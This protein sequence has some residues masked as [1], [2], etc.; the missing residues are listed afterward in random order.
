[1][2]INQR[3]RG[4]H[5][6]YISN[7]YTIDCRLGTNPKGRPPLSYAIKETLLDD[8]SDYYSFDYIAK[9]SVLTAN[10]IGTDPDR[11]FF[12]N[13]SMPMLSTIFSKLLGDNMTMLGL[14]PQFVDAVS[15]FIKLGGSYSSIKYSPSVIPTLCEKIRTTAPSVVYIDNP[16]NPTGRAYSHEELEPVVEVCLDSGSILL[17]D[18]AYGDYLAKDESMVQ[19]ANEFNN[20]V[21][22]RSFSKGLGL[23]SCRLGYAVVSHNLRDYFSKI[24]IPFTPSLTSIKIACDVLPNI[25]SF[26]DGCKKDCREIKK[27]MID[28][29]KLCGIEVAPTHEDTPIFLA[30]KQGENLASWFDDRGILVESAHHFELTDNTLTKEYCR[31]RIVGN[32]HDLEHLLYRLK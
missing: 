17:I 28:E 15:E 12:S 7:L 29:L 14:G 27:T 10:Y 31:V 20:V 32:T 4:D 8:L 9:L 13:G 30:Y 23:A 22:T 11:V 6:S 25:D 21:V 1:M 24:I 5:A 18:E 16:N 3:I 26:L 19:F 2:N